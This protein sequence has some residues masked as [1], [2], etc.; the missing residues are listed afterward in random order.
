MNIILFGAQGSGKGTQAELLSETFGIPH[1]SSGDLFRKAIAEKSELGM[2][3]KTYMKSRGTGSRRF[4]GGDGASSTSGTGL[5]KGC[6]AGWF[7]AHCC[8]SESPG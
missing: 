3:A 5:R 6:R 2:K 4:D 8:A 1:V 7:S